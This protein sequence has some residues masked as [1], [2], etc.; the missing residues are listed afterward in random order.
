MGG[1]GNERTMKVRNRSRQRV[2]RRER[3]ATK[4]IDRS[5]SMLNLTSS[6][7]LGHS[8]LGEGDSQGTYVNYYTWN[9]CGPPLGT[10]LGCSS[11]FPPAQ[12]Q[13]QASASQ[14]PGTL[15]SEINDSKEANLITTKRC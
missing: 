8:G 13:A 5:A 9:P 6:H 11:P 2:G 7:D 15:M 10:V 4:L 14:S 3:L 12:E 1:Q